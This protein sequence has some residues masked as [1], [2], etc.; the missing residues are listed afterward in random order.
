MIVE[1]NERK[2]IASLMQG[3][4]EQSNCGPYSLRYQSNYKEEEEEKKKKKTC[5]CNAM[6]AEQEFLCIDKLGEEQIIQA[7]VSTIEQITM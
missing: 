7:I 3:L 2:L 4:A 6:F 5:V 1:E